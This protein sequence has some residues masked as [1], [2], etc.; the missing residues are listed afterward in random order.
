[1]SSPPSAD[2][3]SAWSVP[4]G[5]AALRSRPARAAP[6]LLPLLPRRARQ[7][8]ARPGEDWPAAGDDQTSQNARMACLQSVGPP[9]VNGNHENHSGWPRVLTYWEADTLILERPA[10]SLN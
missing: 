5:R 2:A 6:P 10:W 8:R 3:P 1:M 7:T 4:R 9:Q